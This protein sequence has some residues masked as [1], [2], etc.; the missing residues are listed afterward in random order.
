MHIQNTLAYT[1][2]HTH[3]FA[4]NLSF[5]FTLQRKVCPNGALELAWPSAYK[6]GTD[7]RLHFITRKR[8]TS[9]TLPTATASLK[10]KVQAATMTF[11][12]YKFG[13]NGVGKV[14]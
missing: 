3:T 7:M 5:N 12:V 10:P 13:G 11:L 14:N 2:T 6:Q 9:H 4:T 1:H 8:K